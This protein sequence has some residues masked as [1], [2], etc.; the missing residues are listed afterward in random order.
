[1]TVMSW[2]NSEG[3]QGRCDEK[4]HS[5]VG[6]DCHCMC[7]GRYHGANLRPGGLPGAMKDYE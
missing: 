5:A 4:C 2:G 1:M 7:G 6:P 3:T